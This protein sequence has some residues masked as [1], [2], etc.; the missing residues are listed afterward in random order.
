MNIGRKFLAA[1]FIACISILS[2]GCGEEGNTVVEGE[3]EA[4]VEQARNEREESAKGEFNPEF[5]AG[6]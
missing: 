6:N 4:E 2:V 1:C 3:L 5:G